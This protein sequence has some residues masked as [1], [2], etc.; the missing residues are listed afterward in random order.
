MEKRI[1]SDTEFLNIKKFLI[2]EHNSEH[3]CLWFMMVLVFPLRHYSSFTGHCLPIGN[4]VVMGRFNKSH[5][6]EMSLMV[7]WSGQ[8]HIIM[9]LIT[10]LTTE[11]ANRYRIH[12]QLSS[13]D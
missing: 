13:G 6:E 2:R 11:A 3:W 5:R 12:N 4:P 10:D 9:Q 8:F 7:N 1:H